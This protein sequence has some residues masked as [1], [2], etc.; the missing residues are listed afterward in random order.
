MTRERPGPLTV[1]FVC[2]G[3]TCRSPLAEYVFR[4]QLE[5]AGLADRVTV[6]SAATVQPRPGLG[7][8]PRAVQ[9]LAGRGIDA[10]G[11]RARHF[12]PEWF[13]QLEL[14]VALDR[15]NAGTLSRLASQPAEL[16]RIHTLLSFDPVQNVLLDVSDPYYS[17]LRAFERTLAIIEQASE[18][19]LAHVAGLLGA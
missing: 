3:N 14:V 10:S 18:H 8:D 9:V 7:A 19:L 11:H 4:S 17:D 5:R 6:M 12:E 2:T 1:C 13:A 16:D 15:S